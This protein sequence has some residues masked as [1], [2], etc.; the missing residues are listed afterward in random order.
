MDER[1]QIL[2]LRSDSVLNSNNIGIRE[3]LST[4]SVLDFYPNPAQNEVTVFTNAEKISGA[5]IYDMAGTLVSSFR[6]NNE[7]TLSMDVS[8]LSEGAY[9]ISVKTRKDTAHARMIIRR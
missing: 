8:N 3:S 5:N 4:S 1:I 9:I 7:N 2:S 6:G